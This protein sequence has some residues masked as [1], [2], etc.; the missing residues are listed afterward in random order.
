M[1][2]LSQKEQVIQAMRNMGCF[3]TLK[4]LYEVVDL[5]TWKTKTPHESIRRIL[6]LNKEFFKI[7]PGL[8]LLNPIGKMF[9]K[10]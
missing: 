5:S 7:Q 10:S 9:W 4:R 8:W 3:A 6:Q 2:K 1:K